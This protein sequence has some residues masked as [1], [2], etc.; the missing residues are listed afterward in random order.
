VEAE[1]NT[2]SRR[3]LLVGLASSEEKELKKPVRSLPM[4]PAVELLEPEAGV[5]RAC[6]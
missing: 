1:D 2:C 4:S 6:T 3:E 5:K